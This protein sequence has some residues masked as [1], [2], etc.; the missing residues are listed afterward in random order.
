MADVFVNEDGEIVIPKK[1]TSKLGLKPKERLLVSERYR[2]II[3]E[4]PKKMF[5]KKIENLLKEGL[6]GVEWEDIETERED[7]EI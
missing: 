3:L 6:K 7:R 1:I 4:K 5:G 2:Y